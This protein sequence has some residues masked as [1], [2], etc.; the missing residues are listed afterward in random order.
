M[1]VSIPNISGERYAATVPDTLDLAGRG[2]LALHAL[3]GGLDPEHDYGHLIG[4]RSMLWYADVTNDL[5]LK[6]FVRSA[7]DYARQ[8]GLPRIGWS[9]SWVGEREVPTRAETIDVKRR[10]EGC[11]LGDVVALG[12]KLSEAGLGDY[13]DDVDACVRNQLIEQQFTDPDMIERARRRTLEVAPQKNYLEREF[14]G[15]YC[16]GA[17]L[18]SIEENCF[19][20]SACCVPNAAL[21]LYYAW[22]SIVRCQDGGAQVNLLL[23]RASPW[24]DIDSHLPYEGKVVISNKSA[25]QVAV[26]IPGWVPKQAVQAGTADSKAAPFW[27]GRYLVFAGVGPGE[28]ITIE[29]PVA[30]ET[31]E[32]T[33][34][35]GTYARKESAGDDELPRT[36]Y[37]CRFRGSTL[38]DISPR[39]NDGT[40]PIYRR[41]HYRSGKAPVKE[42][43][44]YVSP[45]TIAW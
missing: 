11:N 9:P 38:V 25:G 27:V 40:F 42:I 30:E 14:L 17:G 37:T 3:A 10:C 29:F 34:P 45:Y 33:V 12:V 19:Y 24:L 22:E 43:V 2:A 31:V 35:D 26:R 1:N 13:W 44:R 21:G 6:E 39:D 36:R 5:R 28:R 7:Y 8:F 18:T 20:P 41:D 32:Y 15:G 4:F 16:G 23:N